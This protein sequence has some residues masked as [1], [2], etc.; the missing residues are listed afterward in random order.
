MK[1][2][3]FRHRKNAI[4]GDKRTF[5]TG[6]NILPDF[7]ISQEEP[8]KRLEIL[9]DPRVLWFRGFCKHCGLEII[10]ETPKVSYTDLR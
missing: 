10:V 7:E 1:D 5:S 6:N 2:W 9:E 8:C 4:E 3:C